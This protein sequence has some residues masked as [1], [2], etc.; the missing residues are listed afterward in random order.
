MF[1]FAVSYCFHWNQADFPAKIE[2]AGFARPSESEGHG[3]P[4]V[5][6]DAD[7]PAR[8]NQDHFGSQGRKAAGP[9]QR[10]L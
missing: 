4:R 6:Q 3:L 8:R 7:L 10:V 9:A 2:D 5:L 1:R